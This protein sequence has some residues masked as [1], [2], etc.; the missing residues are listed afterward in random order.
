MFLVRQT[1]ETRMTVQ[2]EGILRISQDQS[3][4]PP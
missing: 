4:A 2:E 3:F 1:L